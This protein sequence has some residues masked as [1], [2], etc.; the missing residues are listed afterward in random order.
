MTQ[1]EINGLAIGHA[2]ADLAANKA[3][4]EWQAEAFY[5]FKLHAMKHQFF[6]T[7][8]VR[9][10]NPDI[11]PPPDERAWG[12]VALRAKRENLVVG[13]EWVRANS[14]TVHGMVVTRWHSNIYRPEQ[15]AGHD[16]GTL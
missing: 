12:S 4:K 15:G 14:R 9:A 5:A 2:M 7:E 10:A 13:S 16:T 11:P 1:E 8:E 6:T 3:G